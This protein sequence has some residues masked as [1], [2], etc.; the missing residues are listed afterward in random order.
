M[1]WEDFNHTTPETG[2]SMPAWSTQWGPGQFQLHSET[3]CKENYKEKK[4]NGNKCSWGKGRVESSVTP[5]GHGRHWKHPKSFW[6]CQNPKSEPPYYIPHQTLSNIHTSQTPTGEDTHTGLL[7]RCSQ[8]IRNETRL[9]AQQ[10]MNGSRKHSEFT[11]W[12]FT[13]PQ[14]KLYAWYSH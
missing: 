11:W 7:L 14:R 4:T 1:W 13:L 8:E 5:Q 3:L 6:R 10:Q 2:E 12:N 9:D